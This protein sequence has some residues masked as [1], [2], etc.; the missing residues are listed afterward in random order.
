MS[1]VTVT[2]IS[3][4]LQIEEEEAK[5]SGI[6]PGSS[7]Q[8]ATSSEGNLSISIVRSGPYQGIPNFT[9]PY[10]KRKLV[11]ERMA[12]AFRVMARKGYLEGTAG[13][14]SVRDPVDPE[15]FWINPYVNYSLLFGIIDKRLLFT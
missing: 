1:M 10:K 11:L 8:S 6:M 2:T 5:P 9:D 15:T 7:K 12:G 4:N 14:I 3:Q 13:H